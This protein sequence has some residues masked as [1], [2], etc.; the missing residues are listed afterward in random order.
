MGSDRGIIVDLAGLSKKYLIR[1]RF[2]DQKLF[3]CVFIK[4]EFQRSQGLVQLK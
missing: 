2:R 1:V 3:L 4:S